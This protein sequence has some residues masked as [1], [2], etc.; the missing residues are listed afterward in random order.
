[1]GRISDNSLIE[2]SNLDF[3]IPLRVCQRSEI[4][5]MAITANPNW[6]AFR[7]IALFGLAQPFIKPNGAPADIS[8]G[9]PRHL[10]P[11]ISM[12]GVSTRR[13]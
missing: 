10:Q 9:G 1:M 5:D 4:A 6:R 13:G 11:L 7:Q 8:L 3:D 2:I 12:K